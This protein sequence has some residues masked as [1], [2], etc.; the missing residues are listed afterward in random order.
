MRTFLFALL[1]LALTGH[2]LASDAAEGRR[3]L[4]AECSRCH[5]IGRTGKSPNPKSPPFR[6][7]VKRYPPDSLVEA[8]GEGITTGHNDMPEFIFEP[9]EIMDIVAYLQG[10]R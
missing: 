3:I 7:V 10:L 1:L 2:A 8:L 9:D 5:A 4:K 6:K